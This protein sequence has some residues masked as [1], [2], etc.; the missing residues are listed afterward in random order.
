MLKLLQ[1]V[2]L[3]VRQWIKLG[4]KLFHQ[5]LVTADMKTNFGLKDIATA[6]RLR[7]NSFY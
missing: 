7:V 5:L 6:F 1:L 4:H 2:I 3:H